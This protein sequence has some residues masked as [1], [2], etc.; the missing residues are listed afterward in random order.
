MHVAGNLDRLN[1]EKNESLGSAIPLDSTPTP[2]DEAM[3]DSAAVR[4][5]IR[6]KVTLPYLIL[7]LIIAM[8]GAYIVT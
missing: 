5:P 7:A 6:L 2:A 1:P 3:Q 4:F 8:A